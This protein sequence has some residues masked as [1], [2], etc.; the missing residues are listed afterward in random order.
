VYSSSLS[1]LHVLFISCT[2]T[3]TFWLYLANNTGYDTPHYVIVS[4][5]L[6]F[7]QS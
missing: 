2:L 1:V 7:H 5:F 4:S 3:S 6:L